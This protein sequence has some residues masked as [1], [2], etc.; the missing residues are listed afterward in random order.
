MHRTLLVLALLCIPALASA[1]DVCA[2]EKVTSLAIGA[3]GRTSFTVLFNA[4]HEDCSSGGSVVEYAI[5]YSTTSF[6]EQNFWS[7]GSALLEIP[8]PDTPGTQQC[9]DTYNLS[10]STTFY[11]AMKSKDDA[12]NWS[13]LSNVVSTTTTSSG[14]SPLCP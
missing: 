7:N 8:G 1:Q 4:P 9:A 12:G 2:P 10:Q 3:V 11:V 5:R 13:P 6:T 14:G